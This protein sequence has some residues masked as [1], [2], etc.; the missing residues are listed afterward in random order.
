MDDKAKGADGGVIE[1]VDG[2]K[3]SISLKLRRDGRAGNYK[4]DK[5]SKVCRSRR[6][7]D[8]RASKSRKE[9]WS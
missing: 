7:E 8:I 2:V 6:Q 4:V 3:M 5:V 9:N 1:A